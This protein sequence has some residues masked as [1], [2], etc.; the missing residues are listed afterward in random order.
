MIFPL[1]RVK[2]PFWNL[3]KDPEYVITRHPAI[4]NLKSGGL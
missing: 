4:L 1:N 3:T 2:F